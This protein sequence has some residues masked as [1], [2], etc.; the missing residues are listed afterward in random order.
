MP[1]TL[2]RS[3]IVVVWTIIGLSGVVASTW[4]YRHAEAA[5]AAQGQP[6]IAALWMGVAVW[7]A[8]GFPLATFFWLREYGKNAAL[9]SRLYGAVE[10]SGSAIM[11]VDLQNRIEYANAGLC[12]QTGYTREELKGR[13]WQEFRSEKTMP[14]EIAEIT[15]RVR[16]GYRWE[17]LVSNRR[18]NG[19]VYP[20]RANVSPVRAGGDR[21]VGFIAVFTDISETLRKE[22][23]LR[24]AKDNAEAADHAKGRFLATMSH[25]VRTPLN[26]IVGF[27]SLLL[28]TKLT[29]E[30]REYVQTIRNSGEALI[31]LTGDI[32]DFSRI[33][34]GRMQL[35]AAPCDLRAIIEDALDIFGGRVAESGLQ[36][37]HWVDP[38]VPAQLLIDSGRL[39]QVVI[40]LVGN[41]LKFTAAGSVEVSVQK[42]TGKSVSVAPFEDVTQ[43]QIVAELDDGGLTLE[44]AV[45]DTGIGIALADCAKLFQP[46]TQLDS[47][48]VRR[49]GGAGLGLAISRHLVRLMGGDIRVESVP[50]MGS[51][52]IF[53]V[54]TRPVGN[55][56]RDVLAGRL[57]GRRV[58]VAIKHPGLC[59]EVGHLL[60]LTGAKV[61]EHAID[62]L[63]ANG[64]D[65]A[66]VDCDEAVLKR[67]GGETP[68]GGWQT[69]RMF[70][71]VAMNLAH[72]ERQNLRRH[73]RILLNRPL[74]HDT[75][76]ELIA[77]ATEGLSSRTLPPFAGGVRKMSVLVTE[78]EEVSQR[79]LGDTLANLGCN[80]R[81]A[82]N[83]RACLEAIAA[84]GV[85]LVFL[86][87]HMPEMDGLTALK[88]LRNGEAGAAHKNTW[89][90]AIS[91]DHRAEM[92]EMAMTASADDF[93]VKPLRLSDLEASLR[94]FLEVRKPVA[95]G[96]ARKS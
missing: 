82:E 1:P 14:K 64:W 58:V 33:E 72:Q 20:A 31:Q 9:I 44:I 45:R 4:A 18:K 47:S 89:V 54:R 94:R 8:L 85:D 78:D 19:E 57:A 92:R 21:V 40:N 87:L 75:L 35:D 48:N 16:A 3:R 25:E 32:L 41:A 55:E 51:T 62:A 15:A 91:A 56:T 10:Q 26:G 69:E 24:A 52:F 12:L 50:G 5:A 90:V 53:T 63:P 2:N 67:L 86:D 29:P 77:K 7:L 71:L 76:I 81:F 60:R 28:D 22:E 11:V 43:G 23:E 88:Q 59:A 34:S 30:Q 46:F 93:L 95:G 36:L 17:G 49:Y 74:H 61:F 66:V 79:L 65:V 80:C 84:G 39:R 68:G 96:S 6:A 83:G 38:D 37:L 13:P 70:A 27:T 42:L 73:F